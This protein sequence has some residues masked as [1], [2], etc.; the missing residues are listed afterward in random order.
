M[1]KLISATRPPVS[2]ASKPSR[3]HCIV[4]A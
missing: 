3:L 1:P 2:R 4:A